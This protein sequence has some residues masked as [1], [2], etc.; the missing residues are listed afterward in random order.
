M[1]YSSI[2]TYYNFKSPVYD[3]EDR[4]PSHSHQ[5]LLSKLELNHYMLNTSQGE[6]KLTKREAECIYYLLKGRTY[7]EIA[8]ILHLSHR[9]IETYLNNIRHKAGVA[10]KED[11]IKLFENT[12]IPKP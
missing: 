2:T 6:I 5:E 9:T 8:K 1:N 12:L 11:L 4:Q 3:T 10:S 7:K